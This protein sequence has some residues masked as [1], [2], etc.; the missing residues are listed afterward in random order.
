MFL[1]SFMH[2]CMDSWCTHASPCSL[3]YSYRQ[4]FIHT[5]TC[6]LIKPPINPSQAPKCMCEAGLG[7]LSVFQA[8][9]CIEKRAT[10]NS[11]LSKGIAATLLQASAKGTSYEACVEATAGPDDGTV[12]RAPTEK[13]GLIPLCKDTF[14]GK[15]GACPG[16]ACHPHWQLLPC[17]PL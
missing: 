5:L 6:L 17:Q 13:Q 12:L 3:S 1:Q 2:A 16:C 15:V 9:T 11:G 14:L 4:P 10:C 8:A 7:H